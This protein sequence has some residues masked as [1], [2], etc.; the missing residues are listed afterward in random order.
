MKKL[1]I[2]GLT[3]LICSIS[4]SAVEWCDAK[5]S[6]YS[7]DN[8][9]WTATWKYSCNS[10]D[11]ISMTN[12]VNNCHTIVY[13]LGNGLKLIDHKDFLM[14]SNVFVHWNVYLFNMS[15]PLSAP[16]SNITIS[17]I[18][19]NITWLNLT[20]VTSDIEGST[21]NYTY[22]TDEGVHCVVAIPNNSCTLTAEEFTTCSFNIS[23]VDKIEKPVGDTMNETM[24]ISLPEEIK[25]GDY[26]Q[27]TKNYE[28]RIPHKQI[29]GKVYKISGEILYY[30][31]EDGDKKLINVFWV[32]KVGDQ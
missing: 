15:E 4:V 13:N 25:V 1:L 3:L 27:S 12:L 14:P 10:N 7:R 8:F 22:D 18:T 24:E 32:K 6:C 26:I 5:I 17:N 20:E 28:E 19:Y 31:T 30:T 23:C 16:V 29:Y 2:L 21:P 11:N 9:D